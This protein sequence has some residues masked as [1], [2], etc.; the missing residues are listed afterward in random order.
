MRRGLVE[1]PHA[2]LD[3][4]EAVSFQER[5]I[6]NLRQDEYMSHIWVDPRRTI[7]RQHLNC[8]FWRAL[9]RY[10]H[11]FR[12]CFLHSTQPARDLA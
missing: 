12:C 8:I 9:R 7:V 2:D 5:H 10:I 6:D 11:T 1:E 4:R 3:A